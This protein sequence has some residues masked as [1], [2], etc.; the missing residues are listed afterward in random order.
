MTSPK[1]SPG[2]TDEAGQGGPARPH[3]VLPRYYRTDADRAGFVR[4]LFDRTAPHYDRINQVF[5][6]G[7]GGR[8]RREA[9]QR[10]GLRPGAQVLDV[11]VG[12][13]LVARE[14]AALVGPGG[15]VTGLDVSMGMLAEVRRLGIPCVQGRAEA[16]PIADASVD[17]VS[18]G[19][20]LRHVPDL[21]TTFREYHRVL[22]P[23]GTVLVLEIGRPDGRAAYLLAKF[24][25]GGIVPTLCRLASPRAATGTL[26][27]Y[28]WDTID[29][30]VPAE[31]ILAA[32]AEA[33]LTEVSLQTVLG[34][35]RAF[36][37][38]RPEAG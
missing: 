33:G 21:V 10:A 5:S 23:G 36:T 13:G 8:Y 1:E 32:L 25:L 38:R 35:F 31:S 22:R 2:G 11:A 4:D 15:G 7:T 27:S 34:V 16:L 18:M 24:Y 6:L 17:F 9:L 28:Y 29:S 26:M 20:A 3:P 19:Y 14:A 37:A 30:C 12:T